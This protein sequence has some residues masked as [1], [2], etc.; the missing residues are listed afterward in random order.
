[1]VEELVVAVRSKRA[2][3]DEAVEG[4][5]RDGCRRTR[6]RAEGEARSPS[7][8]DSLRGCVSGPA[9]KASS[10]MLV[11]RSRRVEV[12]AWTMELAERALTLAE[13]GRRGRS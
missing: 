4:R 3:D 6:P 7:R 12:V 11:L 10:K 9:A 8:S 2:V 1:M 13:V 5:W